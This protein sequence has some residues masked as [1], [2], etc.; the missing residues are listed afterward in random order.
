MIEDL[1]GLRFGKWTVKSRAENTPR[2]AAVWLCVCDC[3][4]TSLVLGT[5][6]RIG[7]SSMCRACAAHERT[8]SGRGKKKGCKSPG[9]GPRSHG[10][11]D[12]KIYKCWRNM[13][14]RCY[15]K[16]HRSYKDYGERGIKV[17]E[18][19]KNSFQAF[20]DYVSTLPHYGEPGRT[21]DR[22][23]NDGNYEPG[24]IRW[25]TPYEQTHNRRRQ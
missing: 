13:K 9:S 14:Q 15:Y 5:N 24:N 22:I 17:C 3:G 23:N 10:M 18:E 20:Y 2:G 12:T 6:L 19:W 11:H 4:N 7:R 16:K 21:L 25:S 8:D 1:T